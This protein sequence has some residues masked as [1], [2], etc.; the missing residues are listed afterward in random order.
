MIAVKSR[1]EVAEQLSADIPALGKCVRGAWDSY[2]SIYSAEQRARH[3]QLSRAAL[4]N[5]EMV[6]HAEEAFEGRADVTCR[7]IKRMFVVYF[8][9]SVVVR[10]KKLDESFGV[11]NIPTKQ[12]LS[13]INQQFEL[14]GTPRLTTLHAG[15]RLNKLETDLQGCYIVCP[16]G[17][18]HEWILDLDDLEDNNVVL[19]PQKPPPPPAGFKLRLVPQQDSKEAGDEK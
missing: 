16:R 5:D 12:S 19:F 11:S 7:R 10:F 13:F 3:S 17:Y 14:P 18:G 9:S 4:V 2:Q 15:Y 6:R 8:G 1:K